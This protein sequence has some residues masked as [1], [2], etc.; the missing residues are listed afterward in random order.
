MADSQRQ[1][2]KYCLIVSGKDVPKAKRDE[3][4][5]AILMELMQEK[6]GV[7]LKK[8]ELSDV[9]RRPGTDDIILKFSARLHGG[10]F[11]RL[12]R[13]FRYWHG[14]GEEGKKINV[15]ICHY[16]TEHDQ[17]IQELLLIL[18][19]GGKI[20]KFR[21]AGSG[22]HV[23]QRSGQQDWLPA[24][25]IEDIN[26]LMNEE[27]WKKLAEDRSKVKTSNMRSQRE[28]RKKQAA[29]WAGARWN[30][31]VEPAGKKR[32]ATQISQEDEMTSETEE[33]R[34]GKSS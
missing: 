20:Q 3:D 34:P 16:L 10:G 29:F 30:E 6:Y 9:H 31:C 15:E 33:D 14:K 24:E 2:A 1:T 27:V 23:F 26:E 18:K 19:A 13:R 32:K 4:T 11:D 28:C 22:R 17:V 8:E 5:L 25:K 7:Q 21:V 12:T